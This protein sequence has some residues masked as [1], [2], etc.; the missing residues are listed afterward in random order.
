[1]RQNPTSEEDQALIL[2][3]IG[4]NRKMKDTGHVSEIGTFYEKEE[5]M[6]K[7][8]FYLR[9]PDH[10]MKNL[11]GNYPWFKRRPGKPKKVFPEEYSILDPLEQ[12]ESGVSEITL[13]GN[14]IEQILGP[15]SKKKPSSFWDGLCGTLNVAGSSKTGSWKS[16]DGVLTLESKDSGQL[17]SV[18]G[19]KILDKWF[20]P[21]PISMSFS[22]IREL[23]IG[24]HRP[25]KCESKCIKTKGWM[26]FDIYDTYQC[27]KVSYFKGF[28]E[29]KLTMEKIKRHLLMC[30][31]T[32]VLGDKFVS[33]D[34]LWS[35]CS[36]C[37]DSNNFHFMVKDNGFLE[38][39]D[40]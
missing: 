8:D 17:L 31:G 23:I 39:K 28:T 13:I 11:K 38:D 26:S 20:L 12:N 4:K 32:M 37:F 1:L 9:V 15:E 24:G 35:N 6:D 16:D 22:K 21:P 25:R 3:V 14:N 33:E 36:N 29:G 5:T 34:I 2:S 30:S 10:E 18:G 7:D 19:E 27:W 40:D